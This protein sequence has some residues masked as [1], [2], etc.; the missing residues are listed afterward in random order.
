MPH[1]KSGSRANKDRRTA[2][3]GYE[4][5]YVNAGKADGFFPARLIDT[6]NQNMEGRVEVGRIDLFPGYA[7]FDVKKGEA[8]RTVAALKN[9]R[10]FG[11]RL[12]AEIADPDR[13]YAHSS[14]R[15]SNSKGRHDNDDNFGKFKKKSKKSKQR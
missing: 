2:E 4:R 6:L 1:S 10:Y 7:L 5:V 11:K 3:Q 14:E 12:Y 8:R 13:D 15:K 9:A